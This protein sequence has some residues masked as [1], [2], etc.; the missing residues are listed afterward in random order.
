MAFGLFSTVQVDVSTNVS[1]QVQE[2]II[3]SSNSFIVILESCIQLWKIHPLE[4]V[5]SLQSDDVY[6]WSPIVPLSESTIA[7]IDMGTRVLC[8]LDLEKS[9]K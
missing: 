6:Y 5:R 2:V 1:E 3:L 4:L 9:A 8:K 7:F